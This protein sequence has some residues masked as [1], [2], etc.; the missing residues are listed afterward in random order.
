MLTRGGRKR[1]WE[2]ALAGNLDAPDWNLSKQPPSFRFDLEEL[3]LI[4]EHFAQKRKTMKLIARALSQDQNRIEALRE[5]EQAVNESEVINGA[6]T[7]SINKLDTVVYNGVGGLPD[8]FL[9]DRATAIQRLTK[10]ENLLFKSLIPAVVVARGSNPNL[11]EEVIQ[12]L[13]KAE[14]SLVWNVIRRCLLY[15][16]LSSTAMMAVGVPTNL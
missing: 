12:R 7:L 13:L 6:L 2:A 3:M 14:Q 5:L 16:L 1:A 10:A 11:D 9:P 15:A 4:R 8:S